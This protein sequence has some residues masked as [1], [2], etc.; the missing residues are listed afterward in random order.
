VA[1]EP[2]GVDVV[3]A[4]WPCQGFSRAGAGRGSAHPGTNL[5]CELMRVLTTLREQAERRGRALRW[6]LEN[7]STEGDARPGVQHGR[8]VV[9]QQLGGRGPCWKRP[10]SARWHTV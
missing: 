7:V 5:F 3:I 10:I 8:V 6:L 4:G 2:G 1:G 9:E